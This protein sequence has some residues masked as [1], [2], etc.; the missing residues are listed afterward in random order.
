MERIS[1]L[2]QG[3]RIEE[4][5]LAF[6]ISPGSSGD[7]A[8]IPANMPLSHAT[9]LFQRQYIQQH[10]DVAQ[11]NLAQAAKQLGLHRSNLYR[12]MNQLGMNSP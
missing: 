6:V 3:L 5:D 8:S 9:D 4:S 10:V 7:I 1:Y 11:G 2:T 12:K